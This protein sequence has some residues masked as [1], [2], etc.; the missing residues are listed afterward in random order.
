MTVRSAAGLP[1]PGSERREEEE[2]DL[3]QGGG[4]EGNESRRLVA[5][6]HA[7][8]GVGGCERGR[9]IYCN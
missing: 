8:T 9:E 5:T 4:S 6:S 1:L 3:K 7:K 2:E